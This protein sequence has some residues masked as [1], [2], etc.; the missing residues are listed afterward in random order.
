[1]PYAVGFLVVKPGEDVGA[2]PDNQFHTYRTDVYYLFRLLHTSECKLAICWAKIGL[3]NKEFSF[4]QL[5]PPSYNY[6]SVGPA[7][8][9]TDFLTERRISKEYRFPRPAQEPS[10][11][12]ILL[13][14]F[15][16]SLLCW[17]AGVTLWVIFD[18][19]RLTEDEKQTDIGSAGGS[20]VIL[21][22]WP[23]L[24]RRLSWISWT[25]D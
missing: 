7:N 15:A 3:L 12:N 17:A 14:W 19:L 24:L 13:C 22:L 2:K 25:Q 23:G 21:V 1:M 16:V 10:N 18:S 8:R 5:H 9:G 20:W 6:I 4:L 11:W